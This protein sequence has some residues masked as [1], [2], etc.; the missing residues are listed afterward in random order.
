MLQLRISIIDS[1]MGCNGTTE[2]FPKQVVEEKK[3]IKQMDYDDDD[4]GGGELVSVKVEVKSQ[5]E[6]EDCKPN[7]EQ[8]SSHAT[9]LPQRGLCLLAHSKSVSS[10]RLLGGN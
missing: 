6:A 8:K 1:G 5:D 7:L 4:D 2:H 10:A 9:P 3:G